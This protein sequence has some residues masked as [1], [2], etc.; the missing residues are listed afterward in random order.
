MCHVDNSGHQ[1]FVRLTILASEEHSRAVV[2]SGTHFVADASEACGPC[3]QALSTP[4]PESVLTSI[5]DT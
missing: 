4:F 3:P 5:P 2:A 1:D